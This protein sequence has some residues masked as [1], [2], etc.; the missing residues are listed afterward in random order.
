MTMSILKNSTGRFTALAILAALWLASATDHHAYAQIIGNGGGPALDDTTEAGIFSNVPGGLATPTGGGRLVKVAPQLKSKHRIKLNLADGVE[1]MAVRDRIVVSANGDFVWVGRIVGEPLSRVTLASRKGAV[2]GVID[3]PMENGNEVYQLDP[4]PSGNSLLRPAADGPANECQ[5][6]LP[7][8]VV[9]IGADFP[10]AT[11]ENPAVID[12][13]L[14]YTPATR[15]RYGEAGILTKLNQAITDANSAYLN[16]Q[17]FITLNPVQISEVAYA[18]SGSLFNDLTALAAPGDNQMDEVHA[19]RDQVGADLVAL[20]SESTDYCGMGYIMTFP[21]SGFAPFGFS[22]V[23]SSCLTG[24][25][26]HHEL[27]HNM[28]CHHDR[29]HAGEPG[30]YPYSYGYGR[31][32][33]DGSGF[34]TV[35]AYQC[36]NAV[37]SRINYFSNPGVDFSGLPTGIA[38]ETD[39]DSSADN[40]RTLN[41]TAL[42]VKAFRNGPLPPPAAPSALTA[43][44]TSWQAITVAW[45]DLANNEIGFKLD[46][47][48]DE[49][50][51]WSEIASL[52]ADTTSFPDAGLTANTAYTYRVRAYNNAGYSAYSSP[53][54]AMTPVGPPP[55]PAALHGIAVSYDR[56]DLT[57]LDNSEVETEFHLE[58]SLNLLSWAL[59]AVLPANTASYADLGLSGNTTYHYRLGACNASG[60]SDPSGVVMVT[61]LDPPPTAPANLTAIAVSSSQINLTWEDLSGNETGFSIER[62]LDGANFAVLTAVA[63]NA[64]LFTDTGLTPCQTYSYRVRAFQRGHGHAGFRAAPQ[65]S[66]FLGAPRA[67]L[68]PDQTDLAGQF[69]R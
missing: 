22:A 19:W 45:T 38:F 51:S 11:A 63:A 65:R 4:L 42:Y 5:V 29:A 14:V 62:A 1:H 61:T 8:P 20:I 3:R 24:L 67:Q 18:E 2:A 35:M 6:V 43:T 50:A 55:T 31:C 16:S 36:D 28:G 34:R 17:V 46:R 21:D 7:P 26:L 10:P 40:A 37:V 25:T 68:Q 12:V 53:A 69:H 15:A 30:A 39:P 33:T 57:W 27:G 60:C 47:S 59:R 41:N 44:A 48:L 49:G 32:T 64:T 9:P 52:P 56:I 54:T 13:L 23:F 66:Q 58:R